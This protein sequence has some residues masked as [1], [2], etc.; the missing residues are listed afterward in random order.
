MDV[1]ELGEDR[2]R[3]AAGDAALLEPHPAPNAWVPG[4]YGPYFASL[5]RICRLPPSES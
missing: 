4:G 3:D 5:S 1:G 2:L